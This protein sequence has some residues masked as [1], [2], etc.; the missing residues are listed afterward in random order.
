MAKST[1]PK[2]GHR[3][4]YDGDQQAAGKL[5]ATFRTNFIYLDT[6][7]SQSNRI[8][9]CHLKHRACLPDHPSGV[10]FKIDLH[11]KISYNSKNRSYVKKCGK[12]KLTNLEC[13]LDFK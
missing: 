13:A 11:F 7:K 9:P 5:K 12:I 8:A 3:K 1:R 4:L 2:K 10:L 6:I